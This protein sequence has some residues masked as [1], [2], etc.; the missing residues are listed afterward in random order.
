MRYPVSLIAGYPDFQKKILYY[1]GAG[2]PANI[3]AGY[4]AAGHLAK[5]VSDATLLYSDSELRSDLSL[6][7]KTGA[8]RE[9]GG[10]G[11]GVDQQPPGQTDR[12]GRGPGMQFE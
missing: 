8:D 6:D 5:S 12:G 10:A 11:D 9:T 3:F 2:Y 7:L 4:P 1:H